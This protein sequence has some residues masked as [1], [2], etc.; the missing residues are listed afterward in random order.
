MGKTLNLGQRVELLP[1]DPHCHD[2]SLGLYREDV[3]GVAQ[4]LVHTYSS[5]DG[6][7]ERVAYV[8]KALEVM[9]GL[10]AVPDAPGRLQFPCG[11]PHLRAV[12]RG[13]LDLCK[14]ETGTP[15]E[16]K[17]LTAFD[18]KAAGNL[19]ATGLGSGSYRM[20]FE[21][22]LDAGPRRSKA[23]AKGY[24]KL[25]ELELCEDDRVTFPCKIDHDAMMGMLFFRSQNVRAAM[26]EEESAASRG[27][28][29]APSQQE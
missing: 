9:L 5:V 24:A 27:Q 23:L 15:L 21:E 1:T 16:P 13:F 28:L 29:S 3:N 18:K 4:F 7:R 26:Q 22:G 10:Q 12:K 2:I 11:L 25:C 14:L 17:P 19:T 20:T 8:T 6:F